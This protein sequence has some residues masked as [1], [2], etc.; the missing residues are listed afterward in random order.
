MERDLFCEIEKRVSE[1]MKLSA[2]EVY[3][4]LKK[5]D[6]PLLIEGFYI[7]KELNRVFRRL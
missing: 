3:E 7:W 5:G 6:D 1:W 2:Y 4:K